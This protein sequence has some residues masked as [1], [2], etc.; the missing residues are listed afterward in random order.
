MCLILDVDLFISAYIFGHY[1]YLYALY[2]DDL[3]YFHNLRYPIF[4]VLDIKEKSETL[5]FYRDKFCQ[6]RKT[7]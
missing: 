5:I 3:V 6:I 7:K 2:C 1:F 4:L